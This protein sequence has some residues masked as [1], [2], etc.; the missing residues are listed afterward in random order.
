MAITEQTHS[1]R[2]ERMG[3][4]EWAQESG[5]PE[6]LTAHELLVRLKNGNMEA[7]EVLYGRYK[8]K[9]YKCAMRKT[10]SHEDADDIVQETFDRILRGINGYNETKGARGGGAPWMWRICSN[11]IVDKLRQR[12][13]RVPEQLVDEMASEALH[14]EEWVELDERC[15]AAACALESLSPDDRV[16]IL[17]PRGRGPRSRAWEAAM[18]RL[19]EAFNLRY[20]GGE[21]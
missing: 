8:P 12:Q 20:E 9:F 18:G 19:R 15:R 5:E 11:V 10:R 21:S 4:A 1:E 6:D 7:V 3:Y 2:R 16:Q 14:P 17:R 13:Q